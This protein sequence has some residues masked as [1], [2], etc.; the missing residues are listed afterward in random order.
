MVF[1]ISRLAARP[2]VA[3]PNRLSRRRQCPTFNE[4]VEDTTGELWF[5][6]GL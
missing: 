1:H 2:V 6:R 5:K 4:T 3:E